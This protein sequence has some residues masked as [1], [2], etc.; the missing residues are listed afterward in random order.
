MENKSEILINF[1]L[2]LIILVSTC[3]LVWAIVIFTTVPKKIEP[4]VKTDIFEKLSS[5]SK[6]E[7]LTIGTS[8]MTEISLEQLGIH[9]PWYGLERLPDPGPIVDELPVI[10]SD[11]LVDRS[12]MCDV[13]RILSPYD[14][15][16]NFI[17][18]C[19]RQDM[20]TWDS[21]YST[22][23]RSEDM[24]RNLVNPGNIIKLQIQEF[25]KQKQLCYNRLKHELQSFVIKKSNT[26]YSVQGIPYYYLEQNIYTDKIIGYLTLAECTPKVRIVEDDSTTIIETPLY[27]SVEYPIKPYPR[28][29]DYPLLDFGE[30]L[31]AFDP[32][33]TKTDKNHKMLSR[34]FALLMDIAHLINDIISNDD[35]LIISP[36][37]ELS[38]I[39]LSI[40]LD[41]EY[42]IIPLFNRKKSNAAT[43]GIKLFDFIPQSKGISVDEYNEQYEYVVYIP[44]FHPVLQT[45][46]ANA[47]GIPE[48]TL[49]VQVNLNTLTNAAFFMNVYSQI[50]LNNVNDL[51]KFVNQEIRGKT[52]DIETNCVP[53][54]EMIN[55]LLFQRELMGSVME[56]SVT[57]F[58]S[59]YANSASRLAK[60]GITKSNQRIESLYER[61][62]EYF[63]MIIL[64]PLSSPSVVF[65]LTKLYNVTNVSLSLGEGSSV[66]SV[67]SPNI[68]TG[69]AGLNLANPDDLNW[70][71]KYLGHNRPAVVSVYDV[72]NYETEFMP[73]IE[74]TD[75]DLFFKYARYRKNSVYGLPN[76]TSSSSSSYRPVVSPVNLNTLKLNYTNASPTILTYLDA[77]WI[78]SKT[79]TVHRGNN[80]S[81]KYGLVDFS[82]LYFFPLPTTQIS[83]TVNNKSYKFTLGTI[84]P[85]YVDLSNRQFFKSISYVANQSEHNSNN[86]QFK[87]ID[88]LSN[89]FYNN[90]PTMRVW[91]AEH[92]EH[93]SSVV[94]F[95]QRNYDDLF[96]E[97]YDNLLNIDTTIDITSNRAIYLTGTTQFK[98]TNGNF[99]LVKTGHQSSDSLHALLSL[100]DLL[101]V[102]G[103]IETTQAALSF[104]SGGFVDTLRD[105]YISPFMNQ[106]L[107]L[108][109]DSYN[110]TPY[111]QFSSTDNDNNIPMYHPW[112][113]LGSLANNTLILTPHKLY[114]SKWSFYESRSELFTQQKYKLDGLT[115]RYC[116][117][118]NDILNQLKDRTKDYYKSLCPP[119]SPILLSNSGKFNYDPKVLDWPND[120]T[121]TTMTMTIADVPFLYSTWLIPKSISFDPTGGVKIV[122]FPTLHNRVSQ[123]YLPTRRLVQ[124]LKMLGSCGIEIIDRA[125]SPII[126][127]DLL[128][129]K[130]GMVD[131]IINDSVEE[132]RFY[133]DNVISPEMRLHEY[134]AGELEMVT[135]SYKNMVLLNWTET[136]KNY[137]P[138]KKVLTTG[139]KY[140]TDVVYPDVPN[141]YLEEIDYHPEHSSI[142]S[143]YHLYL[144]Q[145]LKMETIHANN[146]LIDSFVGT[147]WNMGYNKPWVKS[148][149]DST[150]M[151]Q[152]PPYTYFRLIDSTVNSRL[153]PDEFLPGVRYE[154]VAQDYSPQGMQNRYLYYVG[155]STDP[156]K[157]TP[158]TYVTAYSM[159]TKDPLADLGMMFALSPIHCLS[160]SED[161]ISSELETMWWCDKF[162]AVTHNAP[163]ISYGMFEGYFDSVWTAKPTFKYPKFKNESINCIPVPFTSVANDSS[164]CNPSHYY[165]TSVNTTDTTTISLNNNGDR[166]GLLDPTKVD[167][168]VDRTQYISP[169]SLQ[170]ALACRS[171]ELQIRK[172]PTA[173]GDQFKTNFSYFW[174]KKLNDAERN[175]FDSQ[176]FMFLNRIWTS[177]TGGSLDGSINNLFTINWLLL[178]SQDDQ[179]DYPVG[180][181]DHN[182][183]L[184]QNNY[185]IDDSSM[186][187]A[188][189]LMIYNQYKPTF[190]VV[191]LVTLEAIHKAY[192]KYYELCTKG[193]PVPKLDS[194]KIEAQV[195]EV[196]GMSFEEAVKIDKV[197]EIDHVIPD[198]IQTVDEITKKTAERNLSV[199]SVDAARLPFIYDMYNYAI[200]DILIYHDLSH[201]IPAKDELNQFKE[202]INYI[203]KNT[204]SEMPEIRAAFTIENLVNMLAFVTSRADARSVAFPTFHNDAVFEVSIDPVITGY[205]KNLLYG[206]IIFINPTLAVRYILWQSFIQIFKAERYVLENLIEI[207]VDLTSGASWMFK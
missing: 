67:Y 196:I 38:D 73:L 97:Q 8:K 75:P 176:L 24:D 139:L 194:S 53:I 166:T 109:V 96:L 37:F 204:S 52:I 36:D 28:N 105:Y 143:Y 103:F 43:E 152:L 158:Q 124:K 181:F 93:I 154:S 183:D 6:R 49:T 80:N 25:I 95:I 207:C 50:F 120:I 22:L 61:I 56:S 15:L 89:L 45:T 69:I 119:N 164:V 18:A 78:S 132:Y 30:R 167:E 116:C 79:P 12:L 200:A 46:Y 199:A 187:S 140:L 33:L 153:D 23:D 189:K 88:T 14:F 34:E 134:K 71:A 144:R 1:S 197:A 17:E 104:S 81:I 98:T 76:S 126:E 150:E 29:F 127:Y 137:I 51:M 58:N 159:F 66:G 118:H 135:K 125:S 170:R 168:V 74:I 115:V 111:V 85:E 175:K 27:A 202:F 163:D 83:E 206:D 64:H 2:I 39:S 55:K 94:P 156:A 151:Y 114:S 128:S 162:Q 138:I 179:N 107:Y 68:N 92:P 82:P 41:R 11:K 13:L 122:R 86:N 186:R 21:L 4:R 100:E 108:T 171:S 87:Y 123:Y 72:Y 142:V 195:A 161:V 70:P 57:L 172:L 169:M 129:K 5:E 182:P 190:R 35:E 48:L 180:A 188:T 146:N 191:S 173:T 42:Q 185:V 47:L 31:T 106:N 20:W 110:S 130:I 141:S 198:N 145:K 63:R 19:E 160:I 136:V 203:A 59:R 133:C 90:G 121:T 178:A 155:Q 165:A 177:L 84:V 193:V 102:V 16:D 77:F 44:I 10:V 62:S 184:K 91:N 26:S 157:D 192:N 117:S 60:L 147:V 149:F 174:F 54:A 112:G 9:H 65:P 40:D 101:T 113:S 201:I 7:K 148:L 3:F 131:I 205:T 32:A 99:E